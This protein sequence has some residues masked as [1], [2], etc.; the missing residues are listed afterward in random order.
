[1]PRLLAKAL[2]LLGATLLSGLAVAL[3]AVLGA[4]LYFAPQLPST[5]A[6]RDVDLQV[7]M[8]VYTRDGTLITSFGEQRRTPVR[9][10]QVP[11]PM[12]QAIVAAEDD[13][14]YEH[15]GVDYQGLLRAAINLVQTGERT[16]GGSTITMQVARNFFLSRDR[17]YSRKIQEI[18]LALQIEREL[19]KDE[20]LE[21]YLNKIF[22]GHRA[23]GVAAAAQVYY[24]KQLA[25]LTLGEIATIAGLPKAPST[26]N[27]LTNP[28]RAE[29]R[30]NYVLGR[31][32]AEGFID[33]QTMEKTVRQPVVA[34]LQPARDRRVEA[35]YVAE[36]VRD[37]MESR[38]GDEAYTKGLRVYTTIEDSQ[39]EAANRALREG[40]HAYE[41]RQGW[42]GPEDHVDL[43]E[44]DNRTKR[45]EALR[46]FRRVGDLHAA[47]VL[48]VE[49][50]AMTVLHRG[51]EA[52]LD[53]EAL[54]WARPRLD[55]GRR[56]AAPETAHDI[57]EPG[58]VVR[59][60]ERGETWVL[61]QVP[62]VEGGVVAL[63]P[64]DG[65]IS[66]LAGGFDYYHSPF[67]RVV[68][69]RRQP[70]SAFKP[71]V[72]AVALERGYTAAS[73]INDAPVVYNDPTLENE[74]RPENYTRRFYGPTRLRVAL[75]HSRNLVSIRL[76]RQLG[77]D[78]TIS[79]LS[80]TFAFNAGAMPRGLSLAL[81]SGGVTP[82]ELSRGY[83][84]FAN[85]GHLIEPYFIDRVEDVR[86]NVMDRSYPVRV[87]P[88]CD[89]E[90][91]LVTTAGPLTEGLVRSAP[92]VL[93]EHSS[94]L[95]HSM[96][97]DVI[98]S[99][100]GRGALR[101]GR[102]DIAGK[103]GTTNNHHDAWFAGYNANL[104]TTTWI[105]Y[106]RPRSLG[107]GETG[108]RSALPIWTSFMEGALNGAPV[109]EV[110]RPA[111][112]VTVRIDPETGL[113]ADSGQSDAIFETFRAGQAPERSSSRYREPDRNE[114][115]DRLF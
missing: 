74:W 14:F 16:Q 67:N 32:H 108:A 100:T 79:D 13:R 30:R 43:A 105:G 35:H 112:M 6:L 11:E 69:A 22:L 57:A 58:D 27:P 76:L 91:E 55:N 20:I 104:V 17:T 64:Q 61:A 33:Q 107:R 3:V 4:Y 115:G 56:G 94:Y 85:G 23:Y 15:P 50:Q 95:I 65:S 101:L 10:D 81:G 8:R 106:D 39:Q 68:Q 60:R 18:F 24:G 38:F 44:H 86:G 73:V 29:V 54:A 102:N 96:L 45:L 47:L 46:A 75:A 93:S 113:R 62:E 109:T 98:T 12:I 31:M 51:G 70:G 59:I 103:T 42:S 41:R 48:E 92:Q 28:L 89:Q 72:Y 36:M 71:F 52:T 111:G 21:L 53:W 84:V 87:C 40:V 2:W 37:E 25:D 9:F 88:E 114:G 80:S 63:S 90:E 97:Q 19:T 110:P 34:G 78:P 99:G 77:I 5:E 83:A 82:L 66:A 7:P 26:T 1:M 49:D